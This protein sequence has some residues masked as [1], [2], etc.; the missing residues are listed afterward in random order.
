M[1]EYTKRLGIGRYKAI[2]APRSDLVTLYASGTLPCFNYEA[3]L[4]KRPE[5]VVPPMWNMIFLTQD[6]CLR[7]IRPFDLKVHMNVVADGSVTD[8]VVHDATGQVLVPIVDEISSDKT[9]FRVG[10]NEEFTVYAR[11][12]APTD[13]SKEHYG[14]TVVPADSFVAAIYYPAFG[15]A[16]K[17]EC[18]AW[19]VKN[20][21]PLGDFGAVKK[22]GTDVPWPITSE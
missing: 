20:C 5:R 12:P 16:S 2:R 9:E 15:P 22:R 1:P 17:V 6:F 10:E 7:T 21:N 4:D 19:V 11:L 13:D 18:D 14:C 8:I 3:Q